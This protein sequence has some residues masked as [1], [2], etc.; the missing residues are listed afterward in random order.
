MELVVRD[1][2]PKSI[3][4]QFLNDDHIFIEFE[5]DNFTFSD[6]VI[7]YKEKLIEM[8]TSDKIKLIKELIGDDHLTVGEIKNIID[9]EI[10]RRE[11]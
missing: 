2:K 9:C 3:G 5:C 10:K 6:F 8:N 4:T 7:K 11:S 1:L